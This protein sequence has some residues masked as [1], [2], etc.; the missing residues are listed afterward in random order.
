M[1]S[2]GTIMDKRNEIE[3][4]IYCCDACSKQFVYRELRCYSRYCPEC[5]N[6]LIHIDDTDQSP[7]NSQ[8]LV[9]GGYF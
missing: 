6:Q 7:E 4:Q 5:G 9:V 2:G 3:L 1:N 8:P